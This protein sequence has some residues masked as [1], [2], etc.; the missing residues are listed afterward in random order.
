MNGNFLQLI[1]VCKNGKCTQNGCIKNEDCAE[2]ET[3]INAQCSHFE[4]RVNSDC[5]QGLVCRNDQCQ[6]CI[7]TTECPIVSPLLLR[8]ALSFLD[9]VRLCVRS[10]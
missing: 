7:A 2:F 3:C 5:E 9:S 1:S 10:L 4:C 8:I 6:H